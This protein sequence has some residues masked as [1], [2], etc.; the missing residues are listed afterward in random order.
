[1]NDAA[2]LFAEPGNTE[3]GEFAAGRSD[4]SGVA[5]VRACLGGARGWGE[6][7]VGVDAGEAGMDVGVCVRG[8]VGVDGDGVDALLVM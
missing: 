4:R 3:M 5:A 6:R 8:V 7:E 1:V 2:G